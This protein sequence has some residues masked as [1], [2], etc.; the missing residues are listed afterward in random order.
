MENILSSIDESRRHGFIPRVHPNGF[1]QLDLD[2]S[3]LTRLHIWD[4]S[5]PRQDVQTAMHDHEFNLESTV[6]LGCLI[7]KRFKLDKVEAG[8]GGYKKWTVMREPGSEETRL[9]ESE[10]QFAV[11]QITREFIYPDGSYTMQATEF[12]ESDNI[13]RTLTVMRKF[14]YQ[15]G[16]SA[17][18]LVPVGQAPDNN[19]RRSRG[20]VDQLWDMVYETAHQVD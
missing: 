5:L 16:H 12:H 4:V 3:K 13:G 6:Y 8:D 2:T 18:V 15:A 7:N 1:L 14:G 19:F 17:S 11:T 9:I 20:D 10:D